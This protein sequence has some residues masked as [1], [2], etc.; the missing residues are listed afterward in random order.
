[1]N[2]KKQTYHTNS[3]VSSNENIENLPDGN[4][5]GGSTGD[6]K[7][8]DIIMQ[9]EARQGK[10]NHAILPTFGDVFEPTLKRPICRKFKK[11]WSGEVMAVVSSDN[12]IIKFTK[13]F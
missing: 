13:S 7:K 3:Y 4:L 1:M 6:E 5:I 2:V 11:D 9:K 8:D 10:Y 12:Y